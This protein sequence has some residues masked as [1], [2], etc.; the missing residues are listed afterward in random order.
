VKLLGNVGL[1]FVFQQIP[2][3][4]TGDPPSDVIVPPLEAVVLVIEETA[5]VVRVGNWF[6]EF[7]MQRTE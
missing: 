6:D 1:V 3:T 4:V 7:L 5:V 2:L